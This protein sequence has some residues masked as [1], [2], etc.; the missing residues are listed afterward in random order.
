M[1]GRDRS[2]GGVRQ[3]ESERA[4]KRRAGGGERERKEGEHMCMLVTK[5]LG[6]GLR[7]AR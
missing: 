3:T 5:G 6:E 7:E 4:S 2:E 1:G